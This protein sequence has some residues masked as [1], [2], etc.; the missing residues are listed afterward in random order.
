MR[1]LALVVVIGLSNAA[2]ARAQ[3][4]MLSNVD[5]MLGAHDVLH[6]ADMI[7]TTYDLTRGRAF[8]ATERNPFLKPFAARPSLLTG[9]S[10]A[11]DILQVTVIKRVERTHPRWALTWSAALVAVEVWATTNNIVAAG[12][13]QQRRFAA[14]R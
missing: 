7:S 2:F 8:G 14:G 10:S 5:V 9:V 12:R 3:S 6:S 4:R 1:C 13:I 11:I